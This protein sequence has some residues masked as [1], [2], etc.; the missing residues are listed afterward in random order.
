MKEYEKPT[1]TLFLLEK[2]FNVFL[3]DSMGTDNDNDGD[4]IDWGFVR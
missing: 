1:V 3:A 2:N 4:D